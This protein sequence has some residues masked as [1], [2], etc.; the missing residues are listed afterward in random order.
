MLFS[1][2]TIEESDSKIPEK[3]TQ[4]IGTSYFESAVEFILQERFKPSKGNK[5]TL[6]SQFINSIRNFKLE[7]I[8]NQLNFTKE[9]ANKFNDVA[10]E[11]TQDLYDKIVE[12]V[13]EDKASGFYRYIMENKQDIRSNSIVF[14]GE[15]YT[16][17]TNVTVEKNNASI[18]TDMD[19]AFE[20]FLNI[21]EDISKCTTPNEM[22]AVVDR[23][24]KYNKDKESRL[25]TIRGK[26]LNQYSVKSEDFA[27]ELIKFFRDGSANKTTYYM[28]PEG[29]TNLDNVYN[30][31]DS[32][33]E[34]DKSL[35]FITQYSTNMQNNLYDMA[36]IYD[37]K[38]KKL[39][40]PKEF[41]KSEPLLEFAK[42][43]GNIHDIMDVYILYLG[44][45][46]D[47]EWERFQRDR[48]VLKAAAAYNKKRQ[49]EEED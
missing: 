44:A 18:K 32:Y 1:T 38:A 37:N 41:Y 45:K 47:A 25:D 9:F 30:Y 23:M 49:K 8:K 31:Y 15:I 12:A 39:K 11:M 17:Y 22:N 6:R 19:K 10:T 27:T 33:V 36:R 2:K 21:F 20:F 48:S 46:L 7:D 3:D 5:P 26:L 42:L 43:F 13:K 35:K 24:K 34:I 28:P 40:F 16:K 29:Q 4:G 14:K